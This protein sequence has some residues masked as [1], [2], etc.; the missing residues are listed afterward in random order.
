MGDRR[1]GGNLHRLLQRLVVDAVH[2]ELEEQQQRRDLGEPGGDVAIELAALRVGRVTHIIEL[3]IGAGAAQQVGEC[4][5][6]LQR[7]G[8]TLAAKRRQLAAIGVREGP[9]QFLAL[10]HVGREIRILRRSV[11]VGE[12][13]F[14]QR[15]ER[16][17]GGGHDG[18]FTS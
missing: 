6:V 2:L 9:G 1:K 8:K 11:E 12:V 17:G 16:L 5:I 18:S 13:P 7:G 4:L 10:L 15:S 14:G 3:R